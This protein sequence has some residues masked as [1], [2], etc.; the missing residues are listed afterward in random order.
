[1]RSLP[2]GD[3][4]RRWSNLH[5][6]P[7]EAQ[8]EKEGCKEEGMSLRLNVGCGEKHR[9][10]EINIDYY[11]TSG[12]DICADILALPFPDNSASV[13]KMDQLLEHLPS[14][15]AV[16]ALLEVKR[17][18]MPRGRITLA[19]PDM[20]AICEL[21]SQRKHL[22]QKLLLMCSIYGRQTHEG[23]YH[24]SGWDLV[25]LKDIL[26]CVGFLDIK[27]RTYEKTPVDI[28]VAA[29]AVKP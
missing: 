19:V 1:M 9:A 8:E 26:E 23:E 20:A 3:L 14:K 10:G 28:R 7:P 25:L 12:A 24:K 11:P 15:T 17:V 4:G 29:R 5:L 18:L 27:T 16:R 2:S 6:L 21:Y 13:V 22:Q